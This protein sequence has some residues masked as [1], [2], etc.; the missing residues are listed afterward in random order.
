ML[1]VPY[2]VRRCD[3]T[4]DCA[5]DQSTR[6][7]TGLT[8][9]V[10]SVQ[11]VRCEQGL[12][13]TGVYYLVA[14]HHQQLQLQLNATICHRYVWPSSASTR[15]QPWGIPGKLFQN[16][17]IVREDWQSYVFD[18]M[19]Y[20]N[21]KPKI[22][23]PTHDGISPMRNWLSYCFLNFRKS[24]KPYDINTQWLRNVKLDR[25]LILSYPIVLIS[26][27]L[28]TFTDSSHVWKL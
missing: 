18:S 1:S 12:M 15:Q 25:N 2:E 5:H 23:M 24:S 6:G 7:L 19:I 10:S 4:L 27:N 9:S 11:F 22:V 8:C 28:V 20:S 13:L 14:S 3:A 21:I 26:M 17:R 16:V